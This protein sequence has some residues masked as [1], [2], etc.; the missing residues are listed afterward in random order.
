[1]FLAVF[2]IPCFPLRWKH[3]WHITKKAS[4]EGGVRCAGAHSAFVKARDQISRSR[5][6]P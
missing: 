1:M 3:G 5:R 6:A 4:P 2:H